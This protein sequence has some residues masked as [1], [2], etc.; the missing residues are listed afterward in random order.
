MPIFHAGSIDLAIYVPPKCGITKLK[1][2]MEPESPY[3]PDLF[4]EYEDGISLPRVKYRVIVVRSH[5]KRVL[6]TYYDK[7]VDPYHDAEGWRHNH[8]SP[9]NDQTPY[10]GYA[11]FGHW[12]SALAWNAWD[13]HIQPYL[14]HPISRAAILQ[15]FYQGEDCIFH[16]VSTESLAGD[17]RVVLNEKL[18]LMLA[19]GKDWWRQRTAHS[20]N[21]STALPH[22]SNYGADMWSQ[23]PYEN[24][25]NC[26]KDNNALPAPVLMYDDQTMITLQSQL[27][28]VCDQQYLRLFS[29]GAKDFFDNQYHLFSI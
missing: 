8:A 21:Y 16:F 2:L 4:I 27:G 3:P 22:P 28:Y 13:G 24:L 26:F 19:H 9:N 20:I 7:I 12:V 11:S 17:L 25:Y 14:V 5:P 18:G 29:E 23:V 15:D 6:S 10:Q 1:Q